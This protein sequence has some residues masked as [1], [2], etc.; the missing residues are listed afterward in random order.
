MADFE[1]HLSIDGDTRQI[2]RAR[3]NRARGKE[4]V[5]FD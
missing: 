5:L 2:G 4:T 1:V 3:S